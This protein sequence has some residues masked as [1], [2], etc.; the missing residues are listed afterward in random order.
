[1]VSAHR[2]TRCTRRTEISALVPKRTDEILHN[3][4]RLDV[5]LINARGTSSRPAQ[6][7]AKMTR[8][9]SRYFD[10][11]PFRPLQLVV[12]LQNREKRAI[13][14][15]L[16]AVSNGGAAPASGLAQGWISVAFEPPRS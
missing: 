14:N 11:L 15:E 16:C 12:Q 1:M 9:F 10:A 2:C 6:E 13:S 5:E 3:R 4:D 8:T 7:L